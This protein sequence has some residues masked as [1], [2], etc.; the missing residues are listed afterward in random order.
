MKRFLLLLFL[1]LTV[2]TACEGPSG[3]PGRDGQDGDSMYWFVKTYTIHEK[4][5]KLYTDEDGLNPYYMC[6]VPIK[7][8][9][10]DIYYDGNVFAYLIMNFDQ[11]NEVQ[12]P[13]PYTHPAENVQG[14][15]WSEIVH[16]D[17]MPGSIAFYV[18]YSDFA[19]NVWPGDLHFRVVMNY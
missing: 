7:E 12:T 6:E 9:S 13:L 8:L 15:E 10:D 1:T 19:T 4:D 5:W 17:Y 14:Q 16:F 3:P 2:F 11:Q 18:T